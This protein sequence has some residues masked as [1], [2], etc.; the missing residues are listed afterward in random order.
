MKKMT[1][2]YLNS[3]IGEDIVIQNAYGYDEDVCENYFHN[4]KGKL[5]SV[6]CY[7]QHSSQSAILA[8]G[9]E[10]AIDPWGSEVA[11]YKASL[12]LEEVEKPVE[13]LLGHSSATV[14]KA[15]EMGEVLYGV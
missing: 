15:T 5:S 14:Y 1:R 9:L 4:V 2:A 3:L 6:K 8:K 13:L 12:K 10:M 11:I 7:T